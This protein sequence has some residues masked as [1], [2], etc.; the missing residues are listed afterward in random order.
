MVGEVKTKESAVNQSISQLIGEISIENAEE[1]GNEKMLE[2]NLR[3]SENAGE[4]T[5]ATENAKRKEE[6]EKLLPQKEKE[7][8][9]Q[10]EFSSK[11]DL[12]LKTLET[13]KNIKEGQAKDL[14]GGLL[15]SSK[16]QAEN[17]YS[18][19]IKER[20]R[21]KKE[22]DDS[23]KDYDNKK[24]ALVKLQGE[25]NALE[26]VVKTNCNIDLE[27]RT[28]TR[29]KLAKEK[30]ETVKEKEEVVS[31]INANKVCKENFESLID[32]IK[33]TEKKHAWMN[34]L[35]KTANGNL[36]EK[37]KFSFEAYVQT[38]YF[39]RI[40]HRA[41]LRLNKMS[42]GQ[43]DMIRR[44]E[45]LD[46]RAQSG[47]DI[48]VIDHANGSV[49]PAKTL[50]GGQQFLASLSLALGLSDEIQSSSGGVR[51]DT[52]FVDEGF[53]SLDGETMRI[54]IKAL[55]EL[56][57]GNRLVG[58]ISHVEELK[59]KID[60]QIVVEKLKGG[61]GSDCKIIEG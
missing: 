5:V 9:E 13:R 45:P 47:L 19:L 50:S 2:L 42:Q 7:L 4:V 52:M 35:S 11:L 38:S 6:I 28:E 29:D 22:L 33:E 30:G 23:Q 55:R 41:N 59:E 1:K 3:I 18:E 39:D 26:K 14:L 34:T 15:Y 53:G 32:K 46:K 48:D 56:T 37:E 58:I 43:Y 20:S 51:L 8:E 31:R 21:L 44:E 10:R 24:D 17:A 25:V 16:E 57:D 61:Y 60:R 54:A 36:S 12:E 49:R 27:E 40:L